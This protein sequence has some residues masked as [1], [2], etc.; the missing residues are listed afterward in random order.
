M[1][2]KLIRPII[3]VYISAEDIPSLVEAWLKDNKQ[4][5]EGLQDNKNS[6]SKL[7]TYIVS[8]N[9]EIAKK[10]LVNFIILVIKL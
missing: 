5:G 7:L 1:I 9:K 3:I 10:K 4:E 8:Q 6:L 2:L